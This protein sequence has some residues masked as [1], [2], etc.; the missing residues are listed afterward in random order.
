MSRHEPRMPLLV[1]LRRRAPLL[2]R[3]AFCLSLG[4]SSSFDAVSH[5][6]TTADQLSRVLPF[7][8]ALRQH[9]R[10][11]PGFRTV[12]AASLLMGGQA[13]RDATAFA[14]ATGTLRYG[15]MPM[16]ASPHVALLRAAMSRGGLSD[17]ELVA[18]E[19]WQFAERVRRVS[20]DF[21]GARDDEEL[22]AVSRN[23]VEWAMGRSPRVTT[24]SG[25][26][27]EDNV[28]VARVAG[29]HLF[30]VVDGHHRVAAAIARGVADIEVQLTW[31]HALTPLQEQLLELDGPD[32]RT[33]RQPLPVRELGDRWT[34]R[35]NCPHRLLRMLRFVQQEP[36]GDAGAASYLDV[37]ADYGWFLHEMK[38]L[39]WQVLGIERDPLAAELATSFLDLTVDELA[40]GEWSAVTRELEEKFD[41]VS[42]F[43]FAR[44]VDWTSAD[45]RARDL[46]C[47]LDHATAGVLFVDGGDHADGAPQG[48]AALVEFVLAHSSFTRSHDLGDNVD[49]LGDWSTGYGSRLLA[50]SR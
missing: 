41:V 34:V 32:S 30:Q 24:R 46:L 5:A 20:G 37:G 43:D 7:W 3:R 45:P 14:A 4:L 23:F 22:L 19:Y 28:L 15:S 50:F 11:R 6:T 29:T 26:P 16:E 38:L 42:C 10:H 47:A 36:P 25:S 27:F 35:R 13:G 9:L 8:R 40:V 48:S 39:G 44:S 17:A 2:Q 21:F 12:P 33:L 1:A 18:S 31:L 49:P